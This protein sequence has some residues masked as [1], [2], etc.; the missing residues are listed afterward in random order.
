MSRL[1]GFPMMEATLNIWLPRKRPWLLC[2][3]NPTL[4]R[5]LRCFAR[6]PPPSMPCGTALPSL[7]ISSQCK[8]SVVWVI[9]VFSLRT[10]LALEQWLYP[11]AKTR[12]NWRISWAQICISTPHQVIQRKSF[13]VWEA[14]AWY[15]LLHPV[16]K[17]LRWIINGIGTNGQLLLV[18]APHDATELYLASL[19]GGKRAIQGWA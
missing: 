13:C 19:I 1:R 6:A 4:P 11:V 14:P 12:K 10:N 9:L 8:V 16:E 18:A 3:M 2:Q 17:L 15:L 5:P 7:G